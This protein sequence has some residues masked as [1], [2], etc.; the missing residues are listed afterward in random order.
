MR[1]VDPPNNT[2]TTEL[3]RHFPG[4]FTA[5]FALIY[6]SGYLIDFFYYGYLG[7]TDT[8]SEP[9]KLH[10]VEIGLVFM[11]GYMI[12]VGVLFFAVFGAGQVYHSLWADDDRPWSNVLTS[13]MIISFFLSLYVAAI[14]TPPHYF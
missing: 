5:I 7:I 2:L 4:W 8:G 13:I 12:V 1:E 3:I 14:F 11:L 9:L 6:I 10:Y